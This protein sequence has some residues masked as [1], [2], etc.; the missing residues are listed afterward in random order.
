MLRDEFAEVCELTGAVHIE[1]IP[2]DGA[3]ESAEEDTE[4]GCD[5]PF[6][7]RCRFLLLTGP[8]NPS[9]NTTE[10]ARDVIAGRKL[11]PVVGDAQR[12]PSV[13]PL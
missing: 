3:R 12:L 7:F 10:E 6:R 13:P 11:V 1:A 9:H 4:C 2:K 5:G 8:S